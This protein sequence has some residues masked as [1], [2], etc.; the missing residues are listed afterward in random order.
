MQGWGGIPTTNG[1]PAIMN[2]SDERS[3]GSPAAMTCVF[4]EIALT[5]PPWGHIMMLD[6]LSKFATG[7]P[8]PAVTSSAPSFTFTSESLTWTL[9]PPRVRVMPEESSVT[10]F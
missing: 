1:Q 2:V 5:V 7:L 10:E 9:L 4:E 3:T 6:V 8:Y